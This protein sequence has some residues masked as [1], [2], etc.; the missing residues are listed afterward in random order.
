MDESLNGIHRLR[1]ARNGLSESA[2]G[3]RPADVPGAPLA[4]WRRGMQA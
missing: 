4:F 2:Y 1:Q 3:Q